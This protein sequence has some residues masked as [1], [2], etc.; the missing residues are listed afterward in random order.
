MFRSPSLA[1]FIEFFPFFLFTAPAHDDFWLSGKRLPEHIKPNPVQFFKKTCT[2]SCKTCSAFGAPSCKTCSACLLS[3]SGFPQ[4]AEQVKAGYVQLFP[5]KAEQ[6]WR[7]CVHVIF[8]DNV[9]SGCG[10]LLWSG[11]N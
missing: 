5:R 2:G 11:R 10:A 1:V 3:C 4:K 7:E 6:V 8:P 9:K